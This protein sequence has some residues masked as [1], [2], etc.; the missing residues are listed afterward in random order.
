MQSAA[1]RSHY[2]Y[3]DQHSTPDRI[4]DA[5]GQ[6]DLSARHSLPLRP[7]LD[8]LGL[9]RSPPHMPHHGLTAREIVEQHGG[10]PRRHLGTV[11]R[12][13]LIPH[14]LATTDRLLA[15]YLQLF[16]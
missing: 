1:M 4:E 8:R 3:R 14:G 12:Y 7:R 10:V 16:F 11:L 13:G 2:A 5:K 9:R 15:V 6:R